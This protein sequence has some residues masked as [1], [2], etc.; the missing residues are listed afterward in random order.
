MKSPRISLLFLVFAIHKMVRMGPS[1]DLNNTCEI[2]FANLQEP[3]GN[4]KKAVGKEMLGQAKTLGEGNSGLLRIGPRRKAKTCPEKITIS[5]LD[6][7][8]LIFK[9]DEKE[10]IPKGI[11]VDLLYSSLSVCCR[12]Y[13]SDPPNIS[14]ETRPAKNINSLNM[15]MYLKSTDIILP[16][17][18]G[19]E[20][21]GGLYPAVEILSSPGDVLLMNKTNFER[22]IQRQAWKSLQD[23]W[24]VIGL[25]FLLAGIAGVCVWA[26]VSTQSHLFLSLLLSPALFFYFIF[27]LHPVFFTNTFVVFFSFSRLSLS[28]DYQ[29]RRSRGG[30]YSF[31]PPV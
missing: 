17:N 3:D 26:L 8:P 24:P 10:T 4:C 18:V 1:V 6:S 15:K 16:I 25:S 5:W 29:T 28:L 2:L 19:L 13:G 14:F 12:R 20:R 30:E 31:P 21:Y 22:E 23:I 11:F 27:S 7:P 9:P